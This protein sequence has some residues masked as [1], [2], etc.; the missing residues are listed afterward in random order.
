MNRHLTSDLGRLWKILPHRRKVGGT[1][2]G[3]ASKTMSGKGGNVEEQWVFKK[4]E[5]TEE[6]KREILGRCLEF[7][8]RVVFE[9][10]M[11]DSGGK[12]RLQRRG[13][14]IGARLTMAS[15]RIVMLSWGEEYRRILREAKVLVSLLKIY[16][17]DVRQVTTP[18]KMGSS[19][20][21][22][23][24]VETQ[25]ALEEDEKLRE[26]GESTEARMA[27]VLIPAMNSINPEEEEDQC[28]CRIQYCHTDKKQA[29]EN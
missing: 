9:N 17:D 22:K 21:E 20:E 28:E 24:T 3:M 5:V 16:V 4:K 29:R 6:Q 8:I 2:P 23:R 27:R 13:G 11:Y 15:S 10:F 25:E 19:K 12:T 1:A 18:Q 14:P 26:R 7:A